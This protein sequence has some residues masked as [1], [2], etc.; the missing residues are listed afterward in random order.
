MGVS[1]TQ[2]SSAVILS[3]Q[4]RHLMSKSSIC[5]NRPQA[6]LNMQLSEGTSLHSKKTALT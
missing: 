2:Q 4:N 1:K 6:S 3:C 5:G